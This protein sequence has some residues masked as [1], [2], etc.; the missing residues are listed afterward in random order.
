[1]AYT[2][3]LMICDWAITF[4]DFFL[5]DILAYVSKVV[6]DLEHSI[7]PMVN[8][9]ARI[10][11]PKLLLDCA[12][13]C[14]V[15]FLSALKYHV[16]PDNWTNFYRS[17]WLLSSIINSFYSFYWDATRDWDL[18]VLSRIFKFITQHFLTTLLYGIQWVYYWVIGSNLIFRFTF[19]CKLSAHLR[20]NY[21][22]VLTISALEI[23]QQFQ[24]IFFR[25]EN[26]WNKVTSKP[27]I[28]LSSEETLKE[29][30]MLLGN[31]SHNV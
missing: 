10:Q 18:S 5:A 16:F 17:L 7:C 25:V 15:I 9:Q 20:H 27:I 21:L 28:E 3:V 22:T 26:K 8:K 4:C 30:D 1:M 12:N 19:T 31:E 23:L 24:Y 13:P 29:E 6:S 14:L 2:V 11:K